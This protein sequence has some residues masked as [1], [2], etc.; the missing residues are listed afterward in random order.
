V[1]ARPTTPDRPRRRRLPALALLLAI[2]LATTLAGD[3]GRGG[4]R[5]VAAVLPVPAGSDALLVQP[6]A[7]VSVEALAAGL[8]AQGYSVLADGAAAAAGAVRVAVP[9]GADPAALADAIARS[10]LARGVEPDLELRAALVPNDA[11]YARQAPYLDVIRAPA[12]WDRVTGDGATLIAIVD[13]GLDYNHPEFAG[14]LA[15]NPDDRFGNGR[16]DDA[17]GCP[18]DVAG[19]S[20]VSPLAADPACGYTSEAPH[21]NAS[22]DAGHGTVVAGIAA[23]AGDDGIGIAGVDW[24]ARIL[25]VK[26]LDC[27][28]VGRISTAAAGI[29][30][31]AARGAHVINISLGTTSDS[32]VLRE[33][34]EAAQASGALIVA[35]AGNVPGIVTYPGAYPG[36]IAV[37]ASGAITAA[38][39]DYGRI[40]GFSGSGPAIDLMAPGQQIAAPL[41]VQLCD[42]DGWQ[43]E[44]PGYTRASGSSFAAALVAGAA[45]LVHA[46]RGLS[47]PLTRGVLLAALRHSDPASPG[48]LD[49]A[50]ALDQPLFGVAAP[51][52]AR[53]SDPGDPGDVVAP[54]E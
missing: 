3:A 9:A 52:T 27:T 44:E 43:C 48:L 42:S 37:A 8:A 15:L 47:A 46:D 33:A 38:G 45:A 25:P 31:A 30:Y 50:A 2:L 29:R 39:L 32:R 11:A 26:V 53:G 14:R 28:G 17:N 34:V 54:H 4:T 18:D 13:S 22:D 19:C 49:V 1:P 12:A 51:G 10:G 7:G 35:S 5:A 24:D 40:A 41:P 21:W 16:D 36:V 23:A 6:R 20:F